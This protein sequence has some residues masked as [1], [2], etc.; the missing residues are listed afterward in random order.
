M[1]ALSAGV[2]LSQIGELLRHRNTRTTR[3]YAYLM[4]ESATA[5]ATVAADRIVTITVIVRSE[6]SP[7]CAEQKISCP[8]YC[9]SALSLLGQGLEE[10]SA[11]GIQLRDEHGI[12]AAKG[13]GIRHRRAQCQHPTRFVCHEIE[14]KLGIRLAQKH[15]WWNGAS[16]ERLQDR[17]ST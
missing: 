4:S 16:D 5:A 1:S 17:K 13:K 15:G 9:A 10:A 14:T 6:S 3:R 7:A 2:S 8:V 12:G 11:S